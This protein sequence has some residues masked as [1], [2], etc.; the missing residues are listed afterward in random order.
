MVLLMIPF[1]KWLTKG[2]W[3]PGWGAFTFP[4]S[5]FSGMMLT[6]IEAW[7]GIISQ[8]AAIIGLGLATF[9]IPYVVWK[10]YHFWMAGKLA[11]ATGA[12]VV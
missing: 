8:I 5:A 10:T 9:I 12:A 7:F 2:G 11:K 4:L 3:N 6:G 1:V